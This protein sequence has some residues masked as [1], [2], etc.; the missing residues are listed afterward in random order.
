MMV[1]MKI[2]VVSMA[3]GLA[4][5]ELEGDECIL[6]ACDACRVL[7][8]VLLC[9]DKV[10]EASDDCVAQGGSQ[11]LDSSEEDGKGYCYC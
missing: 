4:E 1:L 9:V 6:I 10:A 11:Q 5:R 8:D 2:C 3:S 7:E